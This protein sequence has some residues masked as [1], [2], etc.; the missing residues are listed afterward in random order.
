MYNV[1]FQ[2]VFWLKHRKDEIKAKL[3]ERSYSETWI[4]FNSL[5]SVI[6]NFSQPS[7]YLLR[8][9]EYCK[10]QLLF[11]HSLH[12]QKARVLASNTLETH[13]WKAASD[14]VVKLGF[15]THLCGVNITFCLCD[16]PSIKEPSLFKYWESTN[17]IPGGF[18]SHV[19]HSIYI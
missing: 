13:N 14:S 9:C 7:S 19:F 12:T 6:Y 3:S 15:L 2:G 10:H 17:A 4:M 5:Q 16:V 18:L 8:D 1:S 11:F